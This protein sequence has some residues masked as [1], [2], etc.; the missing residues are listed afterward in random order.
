MLYTANT[1]A[2]ETGMSS[3]CIQVPAYE[4]YYFMLKRLNLTLSILVEFNL[5]IPRGIA[6]CDRKLLCY[7]YAII[8]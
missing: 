6:F 3:P 5:T 7:Y 2:P 4:G 8:H 1:I